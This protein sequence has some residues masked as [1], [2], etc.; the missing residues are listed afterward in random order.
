M[1][2]E[3][4]LLKVLKALAEFHDLTLGDLLEGIVLHAFDG[5]AAFQKPSRRRIKELKKFYGLDLD[6]R[7]SHRLIETR[8][9]APKAK[10]KTSRRAAGAKHKPP[11]RKTRGAR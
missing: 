7:A 6:H 1:R 5:K 10:T 8:A 4:R 3:K 11:V 9:A 2:I